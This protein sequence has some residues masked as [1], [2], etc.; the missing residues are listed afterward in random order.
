[1]YLTI[2]T[3]CCTYIYT[4]YLQPYTTVLTVL[5]KYTCNHILLYL[6]YFIYLQPYTVY[7]LY[8]IY[9]QPYTTVLTVLYKYT[10]NHILLYL[11]PHVHLCVTVV[12]VFV[13][14]FVCIYIYIFIFYFLLCEIISIL[15]V[16]TVCAKKK[17]P[18]TV[19]FTLDRL[20]KTEVNDY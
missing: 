14:I 12:Y 1:M 8:C 11:E 13:Q 18:C 15:T 6:L 7:L 4:I 3:Y 10:C 20:M 5:Y 19:R 17:L 9:L 16:Y 2:A